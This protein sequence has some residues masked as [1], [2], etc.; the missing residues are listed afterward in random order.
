MIDDTM[1]DHV[2]LKTEENGPVSHIVQQCHFAKICSYSVQKIYSNAGARMSLA[3]LQEAVNEL[4]SLASSWK[5]ASV[6]GIKKMNFTLPIPPFQTRI[7]ESTVML[8]YHEL[9]LHFYC[10]TL[11][12]NSHGLLN[13]QF[14]QDCH[15]TLVETACS[16]LE[17]GNA[18]QPVSGL[19]NR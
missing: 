6:A 14:E 7:H 12:G 3:Q 4:S 13:S 2:P 10:R 16:I 8:Q 5:Q 19:P 17:L 15:K 1:I 18:L 11:I 9:V